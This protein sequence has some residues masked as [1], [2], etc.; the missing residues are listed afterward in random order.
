MKL[1]TK[2]PAPASGTQSVRR[3]LQILRLVS[4]S[5]RQGM[6]MS[7]LA[8]QVELSKPS[9]HRLLRELTDSRLLMQG[10]N[11]HYHLGQFAYELGLMATSHFSLHDVCA[12]LVQE[13][14]KETGDTVFLV[15]RS[16]ADSFCLDRQTG[17][18]PIKV[19]SIEVG[20]RQP[21]GVGAGGLALLS[22]LSE[23]D[24]ESVLA[25][26]AES[27]PRFQGL[28]TEALRGLIETTRQQGYSHISNH[29]V[30]GVTGLGMPVLDR[31]G[32]PL[33]AVSVTA[34]KDRMT[35]EHQKQ[36]LDLLAHYTQQMRDMLLKAK[37][38]SG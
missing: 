19:F 16:G 25:A 20:N 3:A 34:I 35:P 23:A 30:A 24:R 13:I 38:S 15:M 5:N 14:A 6:R 18:F 31:V 33:V 36:V 17:S 28:T 8:A 32:T 7:D 11:R 10:E 37:Y 22:F 4:T 9:V 1:S 27:F 21:L 29:A 2:K 26:H 12:P